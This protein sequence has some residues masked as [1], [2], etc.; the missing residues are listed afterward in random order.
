MAEYAETLLAPLLFVFDPAKRLFWGCL[1]SSILLASI[2]VTW[3]TGKFDIRAQLGSLFDRSYW[4]NRS[5]ATDLY[6]LFLNNGIRLLILV[7]IIGSH[8]WFTLA[9]GRFL[10]SNFGDAPE[11]SL[12]AW[13]IASLYAL[14]F[15]VVEDASR[16]FL[17]VSMHRVPFLWRLHRVHHS[18]ENLTPITLFRVHPVES[19]IYF[20]RGLLVF[21][22]VS[23][24][25]IWLFSRELSTYHVL[26]VDLLGFIF[27]FMA[28]NLR[29]SH[30]W[31]SYGYFERWFISPVQHQLHH[32][33]DYEHPNFGTY[34]S[35]WDRVF[36]TLQYSGKKR[37]LKFGVRDERDLA[38]SF[39]NR[40]VTSKAL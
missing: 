33:I 25:F 1:L 18:A 5:T 8:L 40:P 17:H 27:N 19:V 32:S 11:V 22:L 9:T 4:L 3:T 12:P 14:V 20:F 35:V 36:G 16:F 38:D 2:A 24:S 15:F 29:H 23:G 10:Q 28:A 30:V 13:A 31:L 39:F 7:P 34:L 37:H 6:Y 26:G 21:G